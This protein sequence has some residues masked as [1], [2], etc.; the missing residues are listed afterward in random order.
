MSEFN[1]QFEKLGN[2]LIHQKLITDDQLQSALSEQKTSK[3]KL[4]HVLVKQGSI[5]ENELIEVYANQLGYRH[6]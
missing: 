5:T 2:I 1:P 6:I 4:G 3:D